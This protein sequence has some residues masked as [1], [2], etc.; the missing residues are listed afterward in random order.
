MHSIWRCFHSD[1]THVGAIAGMPL[2]LSEKT[3]NKSH[4]RSNMIKTKFGYFDLHL[5]GT[6]YPILLLILMILMV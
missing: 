5:D 2:S 4:D 1:V 3:S 6:H